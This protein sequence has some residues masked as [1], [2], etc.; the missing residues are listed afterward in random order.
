MLSL[1][2]RWVTCSSVGARRS[3]GV[4]ST[5]KCQAADCLR[6]IGAYK[7]I[8]STTHSRQAQCIVGYMVAESFTFGAIAC[9]VG[10]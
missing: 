8:S 4:V 1:H 3:A 7:A 10:G 5:Q 9:V 2:W 6:G